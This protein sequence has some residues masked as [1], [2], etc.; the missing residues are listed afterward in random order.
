MKLY[1]IDCKKEVEQLAKTS[2]V[3]NWVCSCGKRAQMIDLPEAHG[4]I[5]CAKEY[6]EVIQKFINNKWVVK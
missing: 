5:F 3:T 4:A 2:D 6:H 1:C